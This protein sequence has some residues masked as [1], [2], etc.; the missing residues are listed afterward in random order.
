MKH[1]LTSWRALHLA[2]LLTLPL[3]GC[4]AL[5][6][7]AMQRV[8]VRSSPAGAEVWVGGE[9]R[10]VTPL[11]LELHRGQTYKITLILN[12]EERMVVIENVLEAG[13]VALDALPAA[14]L[15]TLTVIGCVGGS[16]GSGVVDFS[17]MQAALCGLGFLIT[18]ASATPIVVDAASGAWYELTPPEV[19]VTF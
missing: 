14:G 6:H 12:G 19:E 4:A 16:G 17:G 7:T 10:G 2:A 13:Y 3:A 1:A 8:P 18:A 5:S 11:E 15:G 9:L